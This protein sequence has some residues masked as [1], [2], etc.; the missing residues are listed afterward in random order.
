MQNSKNTIHYVLQELRESFNRMFLL[1]IAGIL[2]CLVL[3]NVNF[4]PLIWKNNI[5][6]INVLF[7]LRASLSKGFYGFFVIPLMAALPYSL[8]YY[9]DVR[10]GITGTVISKTGLTIYCRGKMLAAFLSGFLS[11]VCG[12]GIFTAFVSCFRPLGVREQAVEY[13]DWPFGGYYIS[14]RYVTYLLIRLLLFGIWCGIWSLVALCI[15][16]YV[17]NASVVLASVTVFLFCWNTFNNLLPVNVAYRPSCWF[18]CTYG[19]GSDTET[20]VGCVLFTLIMLSVSWLVFYR[21][22]K[23][24]LYTG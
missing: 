17:R 23:Q 20:T 3:D 22:V 16:A 9:R 1:A 2:V 13:E 18:S 4:I 12:I 15:S 21:K 6:E 8:G 14:E 19:L 5:P 11:C 24:N 7:Y 10:A